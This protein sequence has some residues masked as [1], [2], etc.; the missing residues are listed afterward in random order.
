MG[1][2]TWIVLAVGLV[3]VALWGCGNAEMERRLAEI[4][5]ETEQRLAGIEAETEQQL[6][7]IKAEM[8]QFASPSCGNGTESNPS[9]VCGWCRKSGRCPGNR[10]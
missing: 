1:K 3:F 2:R 10:R 4:K 9:G 6:A 8:E 7:G 5:G